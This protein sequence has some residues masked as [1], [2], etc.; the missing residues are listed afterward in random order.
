MTFKHQKN[1]RGFFLFIIFA[2]V[3]IRTKKK[4]LYFGY[5]LR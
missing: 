4:V 3:K 5:A 1:L 2:I